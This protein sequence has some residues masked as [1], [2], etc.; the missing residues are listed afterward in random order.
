MAFTLKSESYSAERGFKMS[1]VVTEKE[2]IV[3]VVF[4]SKFAEKEFG[5]RT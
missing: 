1:S 4:L 2:C 3:N 5:V